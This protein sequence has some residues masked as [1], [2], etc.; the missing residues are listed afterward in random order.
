[1]AF[2]RDN[3]GRMSGR[4]FAEGRERRAVGRSLAGR[5]QAPSCS[6]TPSPARARAPSLNSPPTAAA[7][8]GVETSR[9]CCLTA[10]SK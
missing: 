10:T 4:G 7:S 3:L 1:M 2:D 9:D 6:A 8:T 5:D